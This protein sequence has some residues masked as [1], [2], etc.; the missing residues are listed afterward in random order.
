M[1]HIFRFLADFGFARTLEEGGM[2]GTLCGSPMY[3]VSYSSFDSNEELPTI[4]CISRLL[5]LLCP[6]N[7]T[8]KQIYG[9]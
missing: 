3:M 8:V 1:L 5:K 2:A 6:F 4:C 9:V 7:T